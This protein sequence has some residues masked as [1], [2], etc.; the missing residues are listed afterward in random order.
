MGDVAGEAEEEVGVVD[1]EGLDFE[2]D[3]LLLDYEAEPV[4]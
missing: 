2:I 3:A 4:H 1:C